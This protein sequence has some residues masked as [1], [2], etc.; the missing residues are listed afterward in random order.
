MNTLNLIFA[1]LRFRAVNTLLC[2]L[3]VIVAAALFVIGPALIAGYAAD[4][5]R[6]LTQLEQDAQ[7]L[8]TETEQRKTASEKVL[9]DLDKQTTRIMRDLGVN[10]R[11]VHK[12]TNMGDLYTNFVAVDFPEDYVHRLA[13]APSIE[14]IVHVVATLQQRIKWNDRTVLLVGTL[15]VL[16]VS[17]KN[18]EKPHMIKN[19]AAGTVLVGHELSKGLKAGDS[20]DVN[21]HSFRIAQI[22]PEYGGLQDV[23]LVMHLQDAQRVLDKPGMINQILALNCKCKGD[24][25]SVIRAE[26]EGVLPDTQVT[27]QTTQATAR[28]MQRDLVE[29]TYKSEIDKLEENLASVRTHRDRQSETRLRHQA[30][31]ANLIG[32]V[33][34]GVVIASAIF[35]ALMMWL[36]VRERRPE[37]GV[38]RALGKGS[39]TIAGL[40]LGKAVL[41]GLL[42][43]MLGAGVG[44]LAAPWIGHLTLD[45]NRE[46]FAVQSAVLIAV[47]LGAPLVAAMASY[48]PALSAITQDP[49]IVLMDN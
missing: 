42:G 5:N 27:E 44:Y 43:G 17:Q 14:N 29:A 46:L 2:L 38:W 6:E 10:L 49:A 36:N 41:V 11:I 18:E 8:Q 12:D 20:I 23:Q 22:M 40:F 39:V 35:V 37:I 31:L 9:A 15:P 16:T 13:D 26:V 19:V 30:I 47:V 21:G 28:E 24:R 48:L 32:I 33:T 3:A 7:R 34:P 1:E 4:T 25:I 45:L